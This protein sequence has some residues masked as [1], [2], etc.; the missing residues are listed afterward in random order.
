MRSPAEKTETVRRIKRIGL[1]IVG[2]GMAVLFAELGIGSALVSR[3]AAPA[4]LIASGCGSAAM[5]VPV[6]L[7]FRY[8]AAQWPI[9]ALAAT[10]LVGLACVFL[11]MAELP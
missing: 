6:W 1:I 9:S 7:A 4:F 11:L 8:P 3:R 10:S 5:L 2:I